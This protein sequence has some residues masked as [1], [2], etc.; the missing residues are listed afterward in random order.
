[1]VII[2]I[3]LFIEGAYM[4]DYS[5]VKQDVSQICVKIKKHIEKIESQPSCMDNPEENSEIEND[6]SFVV[7][8]CLR[9]KNDEF[10]QFIKDE[11]NEIKI[12][13]D[14]YIVNIDP[15]N[16]HIQSLRDQLSLVIF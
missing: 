1:M 12:I 5:K 14:D 11:L 4:K 16:E 9:A 7:R 6:L 15:G 13:V 8:R 2:L 3:L 10:R